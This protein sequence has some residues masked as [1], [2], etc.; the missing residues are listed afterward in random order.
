MFLLCVRFLSFIIS[1]KFLFPLTRWLFLARQNVSTFSNL[2]NF[3]S[4]PA[5]TRSAPPL[6]PKS[7]KQF[8]PNTFSFMYTPCLN[9]ENTSFNESTIIRVN[10]FDCRQQLKVEKLN[11][12]LVQFWLT[13]SKVESYLVS[14]E[15]NFDG[16]RILM[17]IWILKYLAISLELLRQ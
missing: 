5:S 13:T 3:T 15:F 10:K 9:L 7:L 2:S 1:H 16:I 8:P 14:A 17:K 11:L 4:T 12:C 6:S